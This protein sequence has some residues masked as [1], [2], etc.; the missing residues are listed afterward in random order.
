MNVLGLE[1]IFT[2]LK[3]WAVLK[4][5]RTAMFRDWLHFFETY[6]PEDEADTILIPQRIVTMPS[7][8]KAL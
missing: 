2:T 1:C 6:T 8:P 3:P 5:W 4:H 7:V